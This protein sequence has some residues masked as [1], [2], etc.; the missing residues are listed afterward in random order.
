MTKIIEKH[1]NQILKDGFT[2]LKNVISKSECNLLIKKSNALYSKFGRY[3]SKTLPQEKTVYNLHNKN[4]IFL[5]FLDHTKIYSIVRKALSIGSYSGNDPIIVQQTALR[6]P[7]VNYEQQLHNDARI[8]ECKFPLVIQVMWMLNDFTIE[9]GA[10]RIVLGSQNFKGFPKNKVKYKNEKII[11]GKSGS[12]L[13]F[14]G[15]TWHGSS[16]NKLNKD[17]W[18][19]IYR[20][21]RW[22]LKPSFDFNKNTPAKIFNKMNRVQKEL[23]GFNFNPPV[24]EF[25]RISTRTK[26]A[27]RPKNYRLPR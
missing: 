27:Q 1:V 6:S 21:S 24:D 10:T 19:M 26:I 15:S 12:V 23:L 14:D 5:K 18:A 16:K 13:I 4:G 8:S 11:T 3:Y 22:Y 7:K 17:R 20:Y 2:V 9:N 25:E